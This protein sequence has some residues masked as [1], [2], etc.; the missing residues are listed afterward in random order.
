VAS[1]ALQSKPAAKKPVLQVTPDKT[2]AAVKVHAEALGGQATH[3]KTGTVFP[4]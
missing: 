3:A 2:P 1:F 4:D